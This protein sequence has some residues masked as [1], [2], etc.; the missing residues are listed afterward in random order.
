MSTETKETK[1][2]SKKRKASTKGEK[3]ES[4]KKARKEP[5]RKSIK[6]K[7]LWFVGN[8][9]ATEDGILSSPGDWK[10][11]EK[12]MKK[13]LKKQGR[14]DEIEEATA[15]ENQLYAY[16]DRET[17]ELVC[18]A[19]CTLNHYG[20]GTTIKKIEVMPKYRRKGYGTA[21]VYIANEG[22]NP[23]GHLM[24]AKNVT[25]EAE[26]FFTALGFRRIEGG[27]GTI[28]A[29]ERKLIDGKEH[30]PEPKKVTILRFI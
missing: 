4:E 22:S 9:Y 5:E 16:T 24:R 21:L 6:D 27:D 25:P 30:I 11:V 28:W 19:L 7:A 29:V 3:Q 14:E 18:W 15:R 17:G 20:M 12:F 26:P 23:A 10:K 1:T 13:W 2:E 8:V